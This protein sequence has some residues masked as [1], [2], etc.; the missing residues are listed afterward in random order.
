MPTVG[1]L[2]VARPGSRAKRKTKFRPLPVNS[3]HSCDPEGLP[4]QRMRRRANGPS[5][6]M[7]V[8]SLVAQERQGDRLVLA[9]LRWWR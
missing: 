5:S 7:Y 4:L 3:T 9:F 1:G 2:H 6:R 8:P